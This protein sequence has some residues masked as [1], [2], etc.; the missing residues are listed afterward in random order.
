MTGTTRRRKDKFRE[1]L[2]QF[3][4]ARSGNFGLI[5]ALILTPVILAV[6]TGIDLARTYNVQTKMQADLD[7]AGWIV[8][9]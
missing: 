6:G 8:Y 9:G 7:A 3:A 1:I 5:F 2:R 4:M